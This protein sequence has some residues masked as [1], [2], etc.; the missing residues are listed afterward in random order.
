M[1]VL[2]EISGNSIDPLTLN[3]R[4]SVVALDESPNPEISYEVEV[5]AEGADAVAAQFKTAPT[6]CTRR[7]GRGR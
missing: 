1:D 2:L 6:A 7:S 4:R 3:I 5:T